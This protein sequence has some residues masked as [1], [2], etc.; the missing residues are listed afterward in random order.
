MNRS[1]IAIL[2]IVLLGVVGYFV[3]VPSNKPADQ[4]AATPATPETTDN[5]EPLLFTWENWADPPFFAE[6]KEKHGTVPQSQIWADEDEAFAKMRTGYTP[7]VMGPCSYE[8]GRWQEAG[9]IQPI[10]E[11]RQRDA[12]Q[13]VEPAQIE[14]GAEAAAV[15]RQHD[16]QSLGALQPGDRGPHV[17][18]EVTVHRVD[19]VRGHRDDVNVVDARDAPTTHRVRLATTR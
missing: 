8:F 5:D 6:Y 10:D 18:E 15:P 4:T 2:A 13:I 1:L 16:W 11:A 19:L 9:L 14:T 7:D 12:I 17:A 3:F